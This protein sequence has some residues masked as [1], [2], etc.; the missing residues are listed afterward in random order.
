MKRETI[1][2]FLDENIAIDMSDLTRFNNKFYIRKEFVLTL[3]DYILRLDGKQ[4]RSPYRKK[5]E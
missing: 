1:D 3:A 5:T 2:N 4:S